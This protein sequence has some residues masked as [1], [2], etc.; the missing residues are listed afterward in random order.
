MD[1]FELCTNKQQ[2]IEQVARI[3]RQRWDLRDVRPRWRFR[4]RNA[5]PAAL[6]P[7]DTLLPFGK[8]L[9]QYVR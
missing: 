8:I 2:K 3:D 9:N 6:A 4:L 1:P 5:R 7:A